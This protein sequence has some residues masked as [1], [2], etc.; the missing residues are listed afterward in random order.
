MHASAFK[1]HAA[2]DKQA[3]SMNLLK[4]SQSTY[5]ADYALIARALYRLDAAAEAKVKRKFEIAYYIAKENLAFQKNGVVV[6]IGGEA[7]C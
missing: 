7:Q 6:H 2:S 3:R 5:P 4:Q 1:G